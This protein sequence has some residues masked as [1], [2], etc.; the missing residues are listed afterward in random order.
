MG[1]GEAGGK[2][3]GGTA[4]RSWSGVK[5]CRGPRNPL[6]SCVSAEP[7]LSSLGLPGVMPPLPR[8]PSGPMLRFGFEVSAERAL[9]VSFL[10]SGYFCSPQSL[11]GPVWKAKD[12]KSL[13]FPS[14]VPR[15]PAAGPKPGARAARPRE[16]PR[17]PPVPSETGITATMKNERHLASFH[18]RPQRRTPSK[19]RPI[20][21]L[22]HA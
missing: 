17:S 4:R 1:S 12:P 20:S 2:R 13:S 14:F 7:V 5:G 10:Y 19:E 8:G 21:I 6:G 22:T 16:S 11:K 15:R 3:Q 18:P 9:A